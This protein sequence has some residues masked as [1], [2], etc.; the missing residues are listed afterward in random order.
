MIVVEV[1][2]VGGGGSSTCD[3]IL[4]IFCMGNYIVRIIICTDTKNA[5]C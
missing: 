2:V 1:V 4:I 5:L 3:G